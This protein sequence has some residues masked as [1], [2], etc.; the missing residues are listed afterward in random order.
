V[1]GA[2]TLADECYRG[3]GVGTPREIA[4]GMLESIISRSRSRFLHDLAAGTG[5]VAWISFAIAA[6][7]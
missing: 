4:T 1:T 6:F 7:A 2:D 5:L 3:L